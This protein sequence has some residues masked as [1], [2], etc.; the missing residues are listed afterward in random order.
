MRMF[1]KAQFLGI[2]AVAVMA[3][4]AFAQE[5]PLHALWLGGGFDIGTPFSSYKESK[6]VL[7]ARFPAYQINGRLSFRYIFLDRI[8]IEL[9]A[10][11]Y[12][13]HITFTDKNFQSRYPDFKLKMKN[14]I[15]YPGL[16]ASIFYRQPIIPGIY[17]Y[18]LVGYSW[19]YIGKREVSETKNFLKGNEDISMTNRFSAKNNAYLFEAGMQNELGDRSMMTYALQYQHGLSTMAEGSYQVA[20]NGNVLTNDI[21]SSNGSYMAFSIKYHYLLFKKDK[22]EK[23]FVPPRIVTPPP[24]P[25][26]KLPEPEILSTKLNGRKLV[27]THRLIVNRPNVTIKVWDHEE[28]DGDIVSLNLDDNW[29]IQNYELQKTPKI[30]PAVMHFGSNKLISYAI[31]L[32]KYKPNTAAILVSDGTTEQRVILESDMNTSSVIEI[33]YNPE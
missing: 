13:Q 27:V 23:A 15:F 33:I 32:G 6:N 25:T 16:N 28:I 19:N 11:Q 3:K 26:G 7:K 5:T 31:N 29:L 22:P 24:K 30:I 2:M 9:G 18:G 1:W 10:V 17:L 8:G 4:S 14:D 20:Q 12:F 21:F